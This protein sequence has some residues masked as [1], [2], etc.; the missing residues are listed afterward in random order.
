MKLPKVNSPGIQRIVHH[1][2]FQVV[3]HRPIKIISKYDVP[4]L[5]GYNKQGNTVFFDRHF[6]PYMPWKGKKVDLRPFI[7]FHEIG[8]NALLNQ[9][10][11]RYQQAHHIITHFELRL[12]K[13]AG[14][15]TRYYDRFLKPQI[16]GIY[17]EKLQKVPKNLDLRPYKDEH[18]RRILRSLQ[19]GKDVRTFT[20]KVSIHRHRH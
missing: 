9:F 8:E 15:D 5:A 19:Q 3:F 6:N 2:N 10:G 14:I 17:N 4:Y 20:R 1:P 18:E 7:A 16:K 11:Y 13:Q 12:V